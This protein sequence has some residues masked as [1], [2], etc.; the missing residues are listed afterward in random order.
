MK[1]KLNSL[2]PVMSRALFGVFRSLVLDARVAYSADDANALLDD[3]WHL[4]NVETMDSPRRG[5][6]SRIRF[7][8]VR[9]TCLGIL[10]PKR[11]NQH[12]LVRPIAFG[13]WPFD[14]NGNQVPSLIPDFLGNVQVAVNSGFKFADFHKLGEVHSGGGSSRVGLKISSPNV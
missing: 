11:I 10:M 8:L 9:S 3:G 5:T 1:K 12:I 7:M 4:N 6:R 2:W 13:F 14:A